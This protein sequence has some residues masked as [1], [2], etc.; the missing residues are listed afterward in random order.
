VIDVIKER[1][2][3]LIRLEQIFNDEIHSMCGIIN[4][5]L[6]IHSLLAV[7]EIVLY[8]F[9]CLQAEI[10]NK[11]TCYLFGEYDKHEAPYSTLENK[12][13]EFREQYLALIFEKKN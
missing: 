1:K 7:K 5:P 12:L 9:K 11:I 8:S 6:S 3:M 10:M 4:A 13:D 2:Y